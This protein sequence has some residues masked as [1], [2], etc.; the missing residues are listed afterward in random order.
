[1]IESL[2]PSHSM[3]DYMEC[4]GDLMNP[5]IT[6]SSIKEFYNKV[7]FLNSKHQETY[8]YTISN[9]ILGAYTILYEYKLRYNHPK[10]YI[11]DVAIHPDHRGQGIGKELVKHA[12]TVAKARD[13]Y[14]IVLTCH[15]NLVTFYGELGFEK[16]V[17]F[18]SS[19]IL[20]MEL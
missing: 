13:C 9:K 12:I 19:Q 2:K 10:A 11:E 1:M 3:T 15:D 20:N 18:M 17:N 6:P 8:V 14:K 5:E 7:V 4:L 16:D